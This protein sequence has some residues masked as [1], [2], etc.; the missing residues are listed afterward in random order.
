M[1]AGFYY[2]WTAA[3]L[4]HKQA[5]FMVALWQD[6]GL[7]PHPDVTRDFKQANFGFLEKIDASSMMH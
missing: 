2:I 3:S 7:I 1:E 5:R 4:N 6:N